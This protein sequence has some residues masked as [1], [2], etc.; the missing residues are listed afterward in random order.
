MMDYLKE[1]GL[2]DEQINSFRNLVINTGNNIDIFEVEDDE[3]KKILN[4]FVNIGVT[5]IYGIMMTNPS[6]FHDTVSSIKERI[7]EYGNNEEL[8]NLLNRDSNNLSLIGML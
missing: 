4:L 7:D 3:I 5:N 6:L 2:N 1:Y 8:A